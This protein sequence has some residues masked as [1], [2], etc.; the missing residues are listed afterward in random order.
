MLSIQQAAQF[1]GVSP[2]TLRRWE[3]KGIIAPYRTQGNHRR[4]SRAQLRAIFLHE[5][6]HPTTDHSFGQ[7]YLYARVSTYK[8]KK[9]GNLDRQ[10][11]RLKQFHRIRYGDKEPYVVIQDYGS[12]LNSKRRGLLRLMRDAQHGKV[13]RIFITFPDQLTRFGFLFLRRFFESYHIPI[14]VIDEAPSADLQKQLV[15]DMMSLI[16]S[17]SGKL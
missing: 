7:T 8:Q 13:A 1:L 10:V 2:V 16:A 12:G 9:A 6:F 3:Q 14:I 11:Q 5:P 17:F 4:Y 15:T